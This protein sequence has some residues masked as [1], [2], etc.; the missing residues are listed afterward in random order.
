M[1]W[2]S[3]HSLVYVYFSH[4]SEEN[5][6]K[7]DDEEITILTEPNCSTDSIKSRRKCTKTPTKNNRKRPQNTELLDAAVE[8]ED[9]VEIIAEPDQPIEIFEDLPTQERKSRKPRP[10][11]ESLLNHL[12]SIIGAD[13]DVTEDEVFKVRTFFWFIFY[14]RIMMES[15]LQN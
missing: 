2:I 7:D 8:N 1:N 12:R 5:R 6:R 11:K 4:S 14:Y 9:P 3:T 13:D 10:G 15:T